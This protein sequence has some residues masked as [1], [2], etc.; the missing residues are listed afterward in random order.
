MKKAMKPAYYSYYDE[1]QIRHMLTLF[2][3]IQW[4]LSRTELYALVAP[5]EWDPKPYYNPP[6]VVFQLPNGKTAAEPKIWFDDVEAIQVVTLLDIYMESEETTQAKVRLDILVAEMFGEPQRVW[7]EYGNVNKRWILPTRARLTVSHS[8]R[9]FCFSVTSP[10]KAER[11]EKIATVTADRFRVAPAADILSI[12]DFFLDLPW[13]SKKTDVLLQA[14]RLGW[15]SQGDW[16]RSKLPVVDPSVRA[17]SVGTN[18][19]TITWSWDDH[20]QR[21]ILHTELLPELTLD[22]ISVKVTDSFPIDIFNKDPLPPDQTAIINQ[23]EQYVIS[24]VESRL[25]SVQKR[26]PEPY[27]AAL[28]TLPSGSVISVNWAK[29]CVNLSWKRPLRPVPQPTPAGVFL[30]WCIL[31]SQISHDFMQNQTEFYAIKNHQISSTEWLQQVR[32][33]LISHEDLSDQARAFYDSYFGLGYLKDWNTAFPDGKPDPYTAAKVMDEYITN[34]FKMWQAGEDLSGRCDLIVLVAEPVDSQPPHMALG[35]LPVWPEDKSF[36]WPLCRCCHRPLRFEARVL[37]PN[38]P[39]GMTRYLLLFMCTDELCPTWEWDGGANAVLVVNETDRL[40]LVEAPDQM[41]IRRS[42]CR[43]WSKNM[44]AGPFGIPGHAAN[45]QSPYN[46]L[47][48]QVS[49]IKPGEPHLDLGGTLIGSLGGQPEFLQDEEYPSCPNCG[50]AMS[51][52]AHLEGKSP[53]REK[54][55]LGGGC[56]YLFSCPCSPAAAFLWQQ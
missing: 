24:V 37:D 9:D 53:T 10:H 34:A 8:P 12:L 29:Y 36:S 25:G 22:E 56:G 41:A 43:V 31:H 45:L 4:P 54:M 47:R 1:T 26:Q 13:P 3:G 55:N 33:G 23:A 52:A 50:K 48:E 42:V 16:V 11:D 32:G 44:G 40:A 27:R 15:Q 49:K 17:T 18:A 20:Q 21:Q 38:A 28:W 7:E 2:T 14:E 51:F 46:A 5:L 30:D 35:G 19:K 6:D 39:A